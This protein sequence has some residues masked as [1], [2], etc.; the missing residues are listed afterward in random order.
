MYICAINLKSSTN[1]TTMDTTRLLGAA[2]TAL[3]LAVRGKKDALAASKNS[4]EWE[5]L[6]KRYGKRYVETEKERAVRKRNDEALRGYEAYKKVS[7][8]KTLAE[9]VESMKEAAK[10]AEAERDRLLI[11]HN[12]RAVQ[13]RE[14]QEAA[15]AAASAAAAPPAAVRH[16]VPPA[17][18]AR[19]DA[20]AKCSLTEAVGRLI[21]G[22]FDP[23]VARRF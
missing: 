19:P 1:K 7:A 18:A 5:K 12:Q 20:S 13:I 15:R 8:S 17:A 23:R 2:Q 11:V 3:I 16:V 22:S 9:Y 21:C 4:N 10:A 6:S 14:E